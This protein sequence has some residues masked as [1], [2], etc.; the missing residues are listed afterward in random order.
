[1]VYTD[2]AQKQQ[3]TEPASNFAQS[4]FTEDDGGVHQTNPLFDQQQYQPAESAA[5][6]A[7][8]TQGTTASLLFDS[9]T[10]FNQNNQLAAAD[11]EPEKEEEVGANLQDYFG[12]GG[13]YNEA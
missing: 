12:G 13:D 9:Q 6:L 2:E 5:A 10:A 4:F 11:A 3:T 1:M 7:E 8:S